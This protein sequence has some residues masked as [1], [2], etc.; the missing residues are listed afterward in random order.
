MYSG[1]VCQHPTQPTFADV[2]HPD[3]GGLFLNGFLSLFLSAD[4]EHG[5]AVSHSFLD[6]FVSDIN[7]GNGLLQVKNVNPG[8]FGQDKPLHLGVPAT[9]L[10]PKVYAALEELT[11][12]NDC[13]KASFFQFRDTLTRRSDVSGFRLLPGARPFAPPRRDPEADF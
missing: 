12:S 7:I 5:S 13:H 4:K 9:G 6:E 11:H 1:K 3:A 10:M 8:A 2:G